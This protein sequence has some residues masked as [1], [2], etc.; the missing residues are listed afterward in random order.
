M[1]NINSRACLSK[2]TTF[3]VLLLSLFGLATSSYAAIEFNFNQSTPVGSWAIRE[4]LTTDDKGRQTISVVKMSVVGKESVENSPYVWIELD[5]QAYKIKKEQRKKQGDRVI[6]KALIDTSTFE[7]SPANVIGNLSKYARTIIIQNGNNDPMMI[8]NG[9]M[10]AQSMM[11]AA[12]VSVEFDYKDQGSKTMEVPAGKFS[13]KLVSGSGTAEVKV[14]IKT[15]K[16]SS[17]VESCY[18]NDIPFG[19]V[20]SS[21]TTVSNGDEST[22]LSQLIEFGKS[23]ATSAITK[24]AQKMPEIPKLF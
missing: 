22:T 24:E 3:T 14:L 23:G 12:G 4:D 19:L 16:V 2:I 21:S 20:Q 17:Q 11:Q 10:L 7:D 13:C 18:S 9:G 6:L 8:E 5:S 15:M 1:F